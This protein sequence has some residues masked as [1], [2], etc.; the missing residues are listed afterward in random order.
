MCQINSSNVCG[1]ER[2]MHTDTCKGTVHTP[3]KAVTVI[4]AFMAEDLIIPIDRAVHH[5]ITHLP[6]RDALFGLGA[7]HQITTAEIVTA[8]LIITTWTVNVAITDSPDGNTVGQ[9]T[10]V[11]IGAFNVLATIIDTQV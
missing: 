3:T 9:L 1:V 8:F 2:F 11:P 6:G 4:R 7:V 5:L 10:L